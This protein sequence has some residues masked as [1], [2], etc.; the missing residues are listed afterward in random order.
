MQ[1]S[2]ELINT[3]RNIRHDPSC[4]V[5]LYKQLA[6]SKFWVLV[7]DGTE[8]DVTTM[9]FL[10][11]PT[12]D[13]LRELPLFTH[14]HFVLPLDAPEAVQAPVPGNLIWP[15]L[16]DIIRTGQCEAAVD[17]GQPHGIRLTREMVLGMVGEYLGE[18]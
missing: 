5:V 17:P 10:T 18:S 13:E 11:Y 12:G 8:H 6:E 9:Q 16:L 14:P 3:L 4:A 1:P 2:E 7:K 15:R